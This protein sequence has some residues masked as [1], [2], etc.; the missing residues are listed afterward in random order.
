MAVKSKHLTHPNI[1]PL[2]GV[3][4]DPPQ[5]ISDM[6]SGGDLVEY[7]AKN[8]DADRLRLVCVLSA[9]FYKALTLSPVV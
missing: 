6:E 8:P 2:L 1:V 5:L 4:A 7:L 3:T 9:P